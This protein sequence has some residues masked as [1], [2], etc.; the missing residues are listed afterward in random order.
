M[1]NLNVIEFKLIF[2]LHCTKY[3]DLK[4]LF[5]C[6]KLLV[7]FCLTFAFTTVYFQGEFY[8]VGYVD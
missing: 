6:Q 3:K 2:L 4:S 5:K 7:Y 8:Y 1:C